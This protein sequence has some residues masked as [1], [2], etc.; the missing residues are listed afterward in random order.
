MRRF[1]ILYVLFL[2][3]SESNFLITLDVPWAVDLNVCCLPNILYSYLL[4]Y[5]LTYF[6]IV[7]YTNQS[8]ANEHE[9]TNVPVS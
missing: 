5:L 7:G 2:I 6:V 9:R 1:T 8:H 3:L 4:A